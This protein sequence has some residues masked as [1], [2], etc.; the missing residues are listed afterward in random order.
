[1]S[2]D[3]AVSLTIVVSHVNYIRGAAL[4]ACSDTLKKLTNL[5]DKTKYLRIVDELSDEKHSD[6]SI[7]LLLLTAQGLYKCVLTIL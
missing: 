1:M 2:I 5:F 4:D 6:K 3:S 7:L